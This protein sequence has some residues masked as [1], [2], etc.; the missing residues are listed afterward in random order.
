[1][2]EERNRNVRQA[3]RTRIIRW[4]AGLCLGLALVFTVAGCGGSSS[5]TASLTVTLSPASTSLLVGNF[6][7]F[8]AV[9]SSTV[10]GETFLVNNVQGGNTTIGTINPT[11]L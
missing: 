4:A 8:I 11:G 10:D 6:V 5:S 3:N 1:M 2:S 7:Q 9:P